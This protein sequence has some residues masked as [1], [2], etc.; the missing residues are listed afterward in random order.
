MK[1]PIAP[2]HAGSWHKAACLTALAAFLGLSFGNAEEG[3]TSLSTNEPAAGETSNRRATSPEILQADEK[4][5]FMPFLEVRVVE[6]VTEIQWLDDDGQYVVWSSM[7]GNH[8]RVMQWVE[9]ARIYFTFFGTIDNET[10]GQIRQW[11]AELDQWGGP[12]EMKKSI[13]QSSALGDGGFPYVFMKTPAS[14]ASPQAKLLMEDL[15]N[16]YATNR[17]KI[18]AT[19]DE[20]DAAGWVVPTIDRSGIPKNRQIYSITD[21][22]EIARIKEGR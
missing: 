22:A 2:L 11:N 5:F 10:T 19:Y 8:L 9:T 3:A 6:G 7:D 4:P 17:T 1:T 21:P 14:G 15:H 12:P 20:K 13:P 18:A 16:Y